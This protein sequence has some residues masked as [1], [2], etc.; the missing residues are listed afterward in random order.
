MCGDVC[1]VVSTC[2]SSSGDNNLNISLSFVFPYETVRIY[3]R[4]IQCGMQLLY[5]FEASFPKL[6][7][8]FSL[9]QNVLSFRVLGVVRI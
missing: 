7:I 1:I 9:K 6:L 2:A 4:H 8:K 5:T 3:I